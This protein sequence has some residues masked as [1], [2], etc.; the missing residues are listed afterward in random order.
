M[1]AQSWF[2]LILL[3]ALPAIQDFTPSRLEMVAI[4]VEIA[5][6]VVMLLYGGVRSWPWL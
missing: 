3:S 6:S 1:L 4:A 2:R 5:V